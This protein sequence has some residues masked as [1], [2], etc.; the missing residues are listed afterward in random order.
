M[1]TQR[2]L[3]ALITAHC[4]VLATSPMARAQDPAPAKPYVILYKGGYGDKPIFGSSPIVSQI[5]YSSDDPRT[6]WARYGYSAE[7]KSVATRNFT[8]AAIGAERIPGQPDSSLQ[9]FT[10]HVNA[11]EKELAPRLSAKLEATRQKIAER[12]KFAP[13]SEKKHFV[14]IEYYFDD[15]VSPARIMAIIAL[16]SAVLSKG[17]TEATSTSEEYA[18]LRSEGLDPSFFERVKAKALEMA[19]KADAEASSGLRNSE[20]DSAERLKEI[21]EGQRL[22]NIQKDLAV[23]QGEKNKKVDEANAAW[24]KDAGLSYQR[25]TVEEAK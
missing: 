9:R 16:R 22:E 10:T 19:D 4:L 25:V 1:L 11:L 24:A 5:L 15:R 3:T 14:A 21:Q 20:R 12:A 8:S 18:N 23:W 6:D 13:F 7:G 17:D 2:A